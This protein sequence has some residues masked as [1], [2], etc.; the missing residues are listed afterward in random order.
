ML[1][2]V[3]VALTLL[4]VPVPES[5]ADVRGEQVV[6]LH[7]LARSSAHMRELERYLES[8]GYTVYNLDYPS[9]TESIETIAAVVAADLREQVDPSRTVHFV[10][11]SL[12]GIVT[13][14]VLNNYRPDNLGRVV[15]LASPNGGTVMADLLKDNPLLGAMFGPAGQEL[16][17]SN[18]KIERVLGAV[19]YEL[20]VIAGDI[21]IDPVSSAMIPGPDDGKVSVESTRVVGMRD[22]ITL[23]ASHTFFP[24]S[25]QVH[26]Q[27]FN[28]LRFGAFFKD[29]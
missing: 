29:Q 27:T 8:K 3:F 10:G 14:A 9:T 18:G 4:L 7:G 28:F 17:V 19:D 24:Q 2:I 12:G 6:L 13:R 23:P 11:Y 15:Q 16:A 20:G 21:S 1:R 25:Q 26:H 22:H 5:H